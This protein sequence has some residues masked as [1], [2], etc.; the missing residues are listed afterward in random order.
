M[1]PFTLYGATVQ[2]GLTPGLTAA[3]IPAAYREAVAQHQKGQLAQAR[4]LYERILAVQPQ[5][6]QAWHLLG[7]AAA[8]S[9]EFQRAA[10]A[11]GKAIAL[12]PGNADFHTNRGNA[13]RALQQHEAALA[14]YDQAIALQAN[15]AAAY[16]NRAV[17]LLEMGHWEAAVASCDEALALVPNDAGTHFS[18]G[19]GL[20]A[21]R[22]LEAAAASYAKAVALQP[23]HAHAHFNL[24]S[25]LLEL[26]QWQA[27]VASY[28]QANACRP[29][30]AQTHFHRAYALH[31]LEH[32]QAALAGYDQ[33]IALQTDY[34]EA[35]CNR[36]VVLQDLRQ[37]QAAIASQDMALSIKPDYAEAYCN[38]GV[39]LQALKLWPA[40]I[41]SFDHAVANKPDY[42]KAYSNRGMALHESM[43]LEAAIA[44]YDQAIAIKP[45]YAEAYSHRGL[46]LHALGQLDAAVASYDQAIALQPDYGQALFNKS[47]SLLLAGDFQAGWKLYEW[48]WED[49][50]SKA[51]KRN[52]DQPL[53]LGDAPLAGKTILLH[54]EQGYGDTIQFCRYAAV[55]AAQGAHVILEVQ[56]GLLNL[57]AGLEGVAQLVEI[58]TPLPV[59]DYHCPLMSLP[60]ACQTELHSIPGTQPYLRCDTHKLQQWSDRLGAKTKPRIGLTWSGSAAHSNDGNR[61][62][63]LSMWIPYLGDAFEYV[64]LQK[65]VRDADQTSLAAHSQVRH[66]GDHLHDFVDTAALCALMDVVVCVDTSVAH[67][68]AALGKPTW[69]LLPHVPDWRWLMDRED[70]PWYPSARLYRQAARGDWAGV[71]VRVTTDLQKLAPANAV[72]LESAPPP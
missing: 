69:V 38:R 66:F 4:A 19:V 56:K 28:D 46:A 17:T 22:Q 41:A 47:L 26:Q 55:L 36:G 11:I 12:F 5:H 24:G 58:G 35:Y 14:C 51:R 20:H 50:N 61:S 21:L 67:L 16:A 40:A 34:A 30:H 65:D 15:N 48:R 23:Q 31:M 25:V 9:G 63:P 7:V 72:S 71:L 2:P 3:Q 57:L 42:A 49:V 10:D 1:K 39:A 32:L 54:S 27:A 52:F 18:R 44:S 6:Y 64:S 43:L 62:I 59:F 29:Q 8:Q 68:S 45:D 37:W 60:L 33:A 53:W 70:T 13:L